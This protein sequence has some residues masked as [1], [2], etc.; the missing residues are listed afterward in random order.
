MGEVKLTIAF[1]STVVTLELH[2]SKLHFNRFAEISSS[3]LNNLPKIELWCQKITISTS[4]KVNGNL[5]SGRGDSK[6]KF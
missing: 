1:T 5:R 4:S 2:I 3:D 6:L